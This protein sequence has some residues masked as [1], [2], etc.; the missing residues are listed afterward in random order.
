MR[1]CP[2]DLVELGWLLSI[3]MGMRSPPW[4][5]EGEAAHWPELLLAPTCE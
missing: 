2:A 1:R 3:W 4:D 5:G